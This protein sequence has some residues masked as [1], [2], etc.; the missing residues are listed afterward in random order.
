ML[1]SCS[2]VPWAR[3]G[4]SAAGKR[5]STPLSRT[6][7]IKPSR[8]PAERGVSVK[9]LM[10]LLKDKFSI[11]F[12]KLLGARKFMHLQSERLAQFYAIVRRR[13]R[14]RR[15]RIERGYALAGVRCYKRRTD[16]RPS[17]RLS[18]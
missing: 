13:R 14:L 8:K 2:A 12:R 9:A 11:L 7:K 4:F 1:L 3:R 18:A 15:R 16:I 10:P 17:R 6:T 5:S